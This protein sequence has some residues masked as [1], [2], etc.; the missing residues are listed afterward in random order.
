MKPWVRF[1]KC[2]FWGLLFLALTGGTSLAE[3]L[4]SKIKL[5]VKEFTLENGMLFL[6]VERPTMPQVAC[7]VAIRAGSALEQTGKTGIAHMLEHMMFKGTKNFG[8]LD[9]KKDQELQDRIEA[10][11][12]AVLK[13]RR[14]R[15]PDQALINA[16]LAEMDALRLEVQKIYVPMAFSSQLGKNGAVG[17]NAYTSKDETQYVLSVPSDMLEQWFSIVSEQLFEPSWREFYVEKEVVQ[18]EWAFRY[19]NSPEGAAWI[20]LNAAAYTAHPYHNPT[21]GWNTDME[22][23]NTRDAIEFHKKYYNPTNAVCVLV[24][25][26]TVENAKKL[27][28][29]YFSRYPAGIRAPDELTKEPPQQGPRKSVRFLKGARTPIVL[30]GYHTARMGEKDFYALDALTMV[31]SQGRGA[32]MPQN[33]VNKGLAVRA[34]AANSD[35]R[36]AGMVMLGGSPNEPDEL[37]I[38]SLTEEVKR[39][40]YLKACKDLEEILI[41]EIEAIQ[42]EQVS[43]REL[44]RIKRLNERDFLERMR[45]NEG[46]AGTLATLEVQTGWRY[47]T[48]YLEKMAEITPEDITRVAKKYIRE[49]NKTSVFIIPAGGPEPQPDTYTEVRTVSGSAAA[50]VVKTD[51]AHNNSIYPT[52]EAW[53]HPLSFERKPKKI[54]YPKADISRVE[55]ATVFYL[56]DRE[57]PLIDLLFLVK[58]GEVDVDDA[59][60]GLAGV[61][62]G[63]LIRGGTEKYSPDELAMVLD[64][65][66]IRLSVSIGEEDTV[67]R[68]SMMKDE[69]ENALALLEEV[70]TRPRFDPAVF[71]VVKKQAMIDLKRQGGDAL[72]VCRREGT[73]WHFKGHPYGRDPLQGLNTIPTITR[74]DLKDFLAKY[75]VPSN[76]TVAVA[77]DI[78]EDTVTQGLEKLF[79]ALPKTKA[80]ER[81]LGDPAETPP[82]VALI[83][84]PGQL[85]SQVGL[86]LPCVRHDNPD[87]W[88]IRLLMDVF[89]GNDSLMYTRLRADMGLV[90]AA[91][92]YQTYKWKAGMLVG[93]IG[94]KGDKT[95]EAI[96]ETVNIMTALHTRVPGDHFEEKRLDALNSF[97]F[98]VDTPE[99]LVEVYARYYMRKEPLDTLGR[100]QDVY[101]SADRDELRALAEK[102]LDPKALQ[103][104]VVGDKAT[105]VKK[106]D[107][108]EITLEED[109]KRLARTLS[110]PYQEIELR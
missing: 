13:E 28:Q 31:L 43:R 6:I 85:Q 75:L 107:G 80:P 46:L 44:E 34:W 10:A 24:G 32:R 98:N 97:V 110:L 64:E 71:E 33:I 92:F 47:L 91:W 93:Y 94:C 72:A 51:T 99:A 1:C 27:A 48:T 26:V 67:I 2:L 25:D 8:T 66:A 86:V 22:R 62:N 60:I 50:K 30:I 95:S 21:I 5:D 83:D 49:D 59:K 57:L 109:L 42:K 100:I 84:K 37:K 79:R 77:G 73:I 3:D 38:D 56:S 103:I 104:F 41:T 12:Q 69:W 76:M 87:Y 89:G 58:A 70:L 36:Y 78:D 40:A 63:C 53:R 90:Y 96:Q 18:R 16:K 52:P 11:Y 54:E 4:T 15:K 20:D 88:K 65:H 105:R 82:V 14:K 39:R 68:L 81:R 45:N 101:I 102:F 61:F 7:R 29:T 74:D 19:I 35:N 108:V 17:V 9:V 23:Y 106:E 55:R